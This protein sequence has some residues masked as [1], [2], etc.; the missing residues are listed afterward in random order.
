MLGG[1]TKV[2]W[3]YKKIMPNFIA[4]KLKRNEENFFSDCFI[5]LLIKS[6]RR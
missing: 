6:Q 4:L 5:N 3:A 2:N 1:M